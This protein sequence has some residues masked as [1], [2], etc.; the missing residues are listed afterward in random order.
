VSLRQ[1]IKT[2]APAGVF[3]AGVLIRFCDLW[4]A[5]RYGRAGVIRA[6]SLEKYFLDKKGKKIIMAK[7]TK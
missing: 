7:I 2:P 1:L 5:V 4:E 3:H 6:K